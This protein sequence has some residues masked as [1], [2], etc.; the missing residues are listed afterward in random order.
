[1]ARVAPV[2]AN[3][4]AGSPSIEHPDYWWYRVR[5]HLLRVVFEGFVHDSDVVLDVGSAD[6]PS[7]EWLQA[8]ACRVALDLDPRG[9]RRGDVCGSALQLPF[10]DASFDVAVAFDVV[11]H[12]RDED[13]V[14]SE[15]TRVLRP[16]G[17]VL[18]SAPAYQWAWT[19]FDDDV[20]HYRR[21]TRRR[22][23]RATERAG[24]HIERRTYAFTTT[25]P[26]FVADRVSRR[27]RQR[28]GRVSAQ[29]PSVPG[30]LD[31]TLVRL[32]SCDA[33]LLRRRD[34]AFGSSVLVA[35]TKPL[36]V[37]AGTRASGALRS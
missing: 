1:M 21:Y 24:L 27:L 3:D 2:T 29:L 23:A 25:F 5:S 31:R 10:A 12:C 32:A 18:L 17:H 19:Q 26:L 11:E 37:S 8:A 14:L 16:G 13:D 20:G 6:G 4:A 15:L 35:A 36:G 28:I 7:V 22:L 30:W 33:T 9:L 34:L